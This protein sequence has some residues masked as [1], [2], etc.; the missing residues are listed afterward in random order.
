M[1][2]VYLVHAC[3]RAGRDENAFHGC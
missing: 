2:C 3:D 1:A